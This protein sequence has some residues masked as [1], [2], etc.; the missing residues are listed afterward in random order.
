LDSGNYCAGE[1]YD[2]YPSNCAG[3]AIKGTGTGIGEVNGI[4]CSAL[5]CSTDKVN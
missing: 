5:Q 2:I 3:P 1:P 4:N